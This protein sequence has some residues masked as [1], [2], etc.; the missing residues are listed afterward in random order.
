[1]VLILSED[2]SKTFRTFCHRKLCFCSTEF[3]VIALFGTAFLLILVGSIDI[4]HNI[5]Y[6]Y[7]FISPSDVPKMEVSIN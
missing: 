7:I 1:M 2:A 6:I 4:R 5:I 3:T